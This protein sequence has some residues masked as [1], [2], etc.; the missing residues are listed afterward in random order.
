MFEC[1]CGYMTTSPRHAAAHEAT[2]G[3]HHITEI[4]EDQ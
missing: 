2:E 4:Q 3:N 1:I